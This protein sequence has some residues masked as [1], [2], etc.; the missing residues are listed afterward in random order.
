MSSI[1][2]GIVKEG[3]FSERRGQGAESGGTHAPLCDPGRKGR[4]HED[5]SMHAQGK[6]SVSRGGECSAFN[7]SGDEAPF[8]SG[9]PHHAPLAL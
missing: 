8:I 4:W 6:R 7:S 1:C 9:V 2:W 3:Q 5:T